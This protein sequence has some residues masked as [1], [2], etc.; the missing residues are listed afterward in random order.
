MECI[1]TFILEDDGMRESNMDMIRNRVS[2]TFSDRS[3]RASVERSG[4][5]NWLRIKA[6][7]AFDRIESYLKTL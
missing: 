2:R 3:Y 4:R 6:S 5:A 7:V 1:S